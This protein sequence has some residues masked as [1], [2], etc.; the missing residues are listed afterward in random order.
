M[1]HS[2]DINIREMESDTRKHDFLCLNTTILLL[3]YKFI[4]FTYC[5]NINFYESPRLTTAISV[6]VKYKFQ[7][8]SN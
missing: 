5:K 2:I 6:T 4:K 3:N 8:R 7:N 1:N